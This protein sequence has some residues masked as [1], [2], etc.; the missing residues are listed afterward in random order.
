MIYTNFIDRINLKE[1]LNLIS[2]FK[3]YELD[4]LVHEKLQ[5]IA[6]I[7]KFEMKGNRKDVDVLD[8]EIMFY[9]ILQYFISISRISTSFLLLFISKFSIAAIPYSF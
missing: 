5:G 2:V 8:I 4:I 3:V 1:C 6:S 7:K 9:K